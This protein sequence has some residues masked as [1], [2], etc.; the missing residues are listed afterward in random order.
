MAILIPLLA[1]SLPLALTWGGM[2]RLLPR[3]HRRRLYDVPGERSSHAR[4]TPT[5]GGLLPVLGLGLVTALAAAAGRGPAGAP[6]FLAGVLLLLVVGLIDDRA[7][8]PAAARLAC[9]LAAAGLL[10][11]SLTAAETV[12][13][14]SPWLLGP[15]L[16]AVAWCINL[17]NFMDGIDGIAGS[18]AVVGGLFLA[19]IGHH[20]QLPGITVLGLAAAGGA[21]GFLRWNFPLRR[22]AMIFMGDAGSTVFG[23]TFAAAWT[24]LWLHE[25]SWR[26]LAPLP[27][28]NFILD[29]TLTLGLRAYRRE[30]WYRP[31]REHLYQLLVRAGWSHRRVTVIEILTALAGVYCARWAAITVSPLPVT[32]YL[33]ALTLLWLAGRSWATGKLTTVAGR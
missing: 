16:V 26:W 21:I 30:T 12:N 11:L 4:P 10:F 31:H 28:A 9:Q 13:D 32:G 7:G 23:F 6:G 3:L 15:W 29:A 17:Y 33:V 22:P 18:E 14:I 25:S 2:P 27:L 1:F 19:W 24:L 8:L 20:E 5:G